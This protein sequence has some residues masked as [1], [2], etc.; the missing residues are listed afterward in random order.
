MR[1]KLTPA[2]CQKATVQD[3]AERTIYWD[4]E[5]PSFG[6]LVT[7][8]GRRS[9]VVQYR[10]GDTKKSRRMK[11]AG[12]LGLVGARKRAKKLLG[13]VADDKDPLHDRRE[14]SARPLL[15]PSIHLKKSLRNILPAKGRACGRL[16][17]A[18]G[19]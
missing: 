19:C 3:G 7:K 16:A 6:L 8:N 12:V 15:E 9:F 18:G 14:Q 11:I 17:S 10:A 1:T 4:A 2:F 13:Q 5:L